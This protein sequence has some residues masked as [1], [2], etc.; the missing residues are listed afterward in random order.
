MCVM[1]RV[2]PMLLL[3]ALCSCAMGKQTSEESIPFASLSTNDTEKVVS[4]A[5]G[6][7]L[8]MARYALRRAH[9]DSKE[10]NCPSL[11]TLAKG[12]RVLSGDCETSEGVVYRG[13]VT[14]DNAWLFTDVFSGGPQVVKD[15]PSEILFEDFVMVYEGNDFSFDGI[16]WGE[17][18]WPT[19][20]PRRAFADMTVDAPG[21]GM[22]R[23]S[24]DQ[25]C[26]GSDCEYQSGSF[27]Q[28]DSMGTCS[29]RGTSGYA[30][31][32]RSGTVVLGGENELQIT[33]DGMPGV[34]GVISV[35]GEE[36]R[37]YC[38]P[39]TETEVADWIRK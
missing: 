21:L 20:E 24:V 26:I 1:S 37:S 34:C 35:E 2:F 22:S 31:G 27:A 33:F 5:T 32:E 14:I 17:F 3:A 11:S 15:E 19:A 23:V 36:G 4:I 16:L 25:V 18:A 7:T 39:L 12:R 9:T 10:E 28:F 30:G 38:L 13:Q 8:E 29:I 6:K